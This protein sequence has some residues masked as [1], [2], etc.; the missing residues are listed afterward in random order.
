MTG[1]EKQEQTLLAE[2]SEYYRQRAGEYEDWWYR[3]AGYD[4]GPESNEHWFAQTLELERALAQF[5]PTGNVLELACGTG[6]WTRHLARAADRVTALD[7]SAE[8]I[9]LNREQV[10]ASNV[11]YIQSDLFGWWPT[12]AYDVCFFGFWLSHVPEEQFAEFWRMVAAA[13]GRRGRVFFIDSARRDRWSGDRSEDETMTRELSDGR[14]FQIVKRFYEP[15][16]L[17]EEL[18]KLGFTATVEATSEYFIYGSA[19]LTE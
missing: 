14:R 2:Q 8:M 11:H 1:A 9:A 13:V 6:L 19:K 10:K 15:G 3:R 12:E 16:W 5:T 17:R 7:G 4:N 18:A